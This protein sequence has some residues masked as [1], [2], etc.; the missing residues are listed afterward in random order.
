MTETLTA[1]SGVTKP[2]EFAP[3]NVDNV[4][5][6]ALLNLPSDQ[7]NGYVVKVAGPSVGYGRGQP[8][9]VLKAADGDATNQLG[10]GTVLMRVDD[11]GSIGTNG[12]LHIASGLRQA[13]GGSQAVWVD[14]EE[15][16]VHILMTAAP[17]TPV[18]PFVKITKQDG[19]NLVTIDKEGAINVFRNGSNVGWFAGDNPAF[20]VRLGVNAGAT[21]VIPIL[22]G[23]AAGQTV[24]LLRIAQGATVFAKFNKNGYFITKKNA[25]IADADL[26]AGEAALWFDSSNTLPRFMIR[27][28]TADG[29]VKS[30]A[31]ALS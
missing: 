28:K 3:S 16:L 2:D 20:G 24:D 19:T 18:Q 6:M 5:A 7:M 1:P 17:G 9:M 25:V 30:G 29:T 8:F 21:D 10:A 13:F 23:A 27:A 4:Q 14:P 15:D 22:V 31:I 26:A 11:D 12:G